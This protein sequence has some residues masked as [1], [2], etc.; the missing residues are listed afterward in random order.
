LLGSSGVSNY[1][2]IGML[3]LPDPYEAHKELED[4]RD[5]LVNDPYFDGVPSMQPGEK[6]TALAFH[7]KDDTREVRRE[8]NR[9]LPF[10]QG[11]VVVG[12]RRKDGLLR[13]HRLLYKQTG[14]KGRPDDVYDDLVTGV[15]KG[16]LHPGNNNEI[17]F[18]RRGKTDRARALENAVEKAGTYT[19]PR[20]I[21]MSRPARV[22]SAYPHEEAGL[23]VDYYLWAVQRL[24]ELGE[25]RFYRAL[26]PQYEL[27]MDLDDKRNRRGGEWYSDRNRLEVRK[28]K[29]FA[30]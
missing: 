19:A 18:A 9:L 27:V 20:N 14:L 16:R 5:D 30:S 11:M 23:I 29:P 17:V 10:L 1:F 28:I 4:L 21:R 13:E 12:I 6:K 15:F 24:F 8:V 3:E 25:P 7:A 2:M 22:A 26:E